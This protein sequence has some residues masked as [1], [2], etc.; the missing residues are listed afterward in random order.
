MQRT[1]MGAELAQ[2]GGSKGGTIETAEFV[3]WTQSPAGWGMVDSAG[4]GVSEGQEP[5]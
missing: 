1:L 3:T 5:Y 2:A 4:K